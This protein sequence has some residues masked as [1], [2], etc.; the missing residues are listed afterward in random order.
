MRQEGN[1]DNEGMKDWNA[2]RDATDVIRATKTTIRK[3]QS[4]KKPLDIF[5]RPFDILSPRIDYK[6]SADWSHRSTR[7][8]ITLV[9]C[10]DRPGVRVGHDLLF[11]CFSS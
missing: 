7:S 2:T 10:L 4:E 9:P 11:V 6:Q 1:T 8:T 3:N 5:L